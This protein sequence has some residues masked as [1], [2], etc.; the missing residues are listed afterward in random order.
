MP[1]YYDIDKKI[2]KSRII[3]FL[4]LLL[5]VVARAND[6]R[7]YI[8]G[9]QLVPI[10]DADIRID[11]E[12]LTIRIADDGFAYVDVD[13][14]FNNLAE[15]K[16]VRIGF[17][18]AIENDWANVLTKK[19]DAKMI[20]HKGHPN[21]FDFVVE[22]NGKPIGYQNRFAF[23]QEDDTEKPLDYEHFPVDKEWVHGDFNEEYYKKF[24]GWDSGLYNAKIDSSRN[25]AHVYY[26]EA[27]FKSG[28]NKVHHTYRYEM[29]NGVDNTF[30]VRYWLT[31]A[32]RWAGNKIGDFT[33]RISAE[34]TAKHFFIYKNKCFEGVDFKLVKGVGKMRSRVNSYMRDEIEKSDVVEVS[35]RN[36]VIEW[37]KTDFH[38]AENLKIC[39][40]DNLKYAV[41]SESLEKVYGK[42][43]EY[44]D[45]SG[46]MYPWPPME[47]PTDWELRIMRN[48]PYASRGYVFKN[49]QLKD[50]FEKQWWYIPDH[51]WEASTND[52][53]KFEQGL[54]KGE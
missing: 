8:S 37:H 34:G 48:M 49:K 38:P 51:S 43:G 10:S 47:Q 27:P 16:N 31:P 7:F 36:G 50:F 53:T 41:T 11:K 33:L 3:L 21:I 12:I 2:M 46:R 24:E 13:Y 17:E 30:D 9:N 18:A 1:S 26:F 25:Y 40:A 5:A 14:T 20:G 42:L 6:G 45:R 4:L 22:I 39:S 32:L 19:N 29:G 15:A 44:Y 52:F 54:L 35:L 23:Y 28:I